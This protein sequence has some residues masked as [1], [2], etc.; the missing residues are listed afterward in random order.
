MVDE[1]YMHKNFVL[2]SS[3][4]KIHLLICVMLGDLHASERGNPRE[5]VR[6]IAMTHNPGITD[7]HQK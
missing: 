3:T 6:L 1:L 5:Y 4:L 2:F 7:N